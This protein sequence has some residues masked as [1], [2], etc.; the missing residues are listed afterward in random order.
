M[1]D[2]YQNPSLVLQN[3]YKNKHS[4]SVINFTNIILGKYKT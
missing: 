1:Q 3:I 4:Y 2:I